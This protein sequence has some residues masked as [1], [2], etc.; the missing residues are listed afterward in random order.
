MGHSA[1]QQG[2]FLWEQ[3]F[4]GD[5]CLAG[6]ILPCGL[7]EFSKR[8]SN[9]PSTN[10]LNFIVST[11]TQKCINNNKSG[12]GI[13]V[14]I[15]WLQMRPKYEYLLHNKWHLCIQMTRLLVILQK[16]VTLNIT[17]FLGT[18]ESQPVKCWYNLFTIILWK[19][20]SLLLKGN[21]VIEQ[22]LLSLPVKFYK[23]QF[24]LSYYRNIELYYHFLW[25]VSTDLKKS[26]KHFNVTS[27][28]EPWPL[29]EIDISLV[30]TTI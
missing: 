18:L 13:K 15:S 17:S 7:F 23:N 11:F 12:S 9:T 1:G 21:G 8:L 27:H 30:C 5:S 24:S 2:C 10:P 6:S 29:G 19:K 25:G 28:N 3:I 14:T 20:C 4:Y 16:Q 26:T 22:F